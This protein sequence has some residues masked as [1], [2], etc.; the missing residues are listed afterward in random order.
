MSLSPKEKSLSPRE[1]QVLDLVAS[2]LDDG[3]IA[4]VLSISPHTVNSY[5]RRI[6]DK[7]KTNDR[8]TAIALAGQHNIKIT[9]YRVRVTPITS[10]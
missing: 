9:L 5:M 8:H 1:K 6:F 3:L 10:D 4:N 2:G 7:F